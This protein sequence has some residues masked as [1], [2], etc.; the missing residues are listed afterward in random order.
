[1]NRPELITKSM[2][3]LYLLKRSEIEVIDF[4]Y[5]GFGNANVPEQLVEYRLRLGMYCV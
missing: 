1:M 3:L 2:R 5:L 4:V